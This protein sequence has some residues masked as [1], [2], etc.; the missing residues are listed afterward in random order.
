[1]SGIQSINSFL[2]IHWKNLTQN[3]RDECI[4]K[5]KAHN[6]NAKNALAI[7]IDFD[8]YSLKALNL[9]ISENL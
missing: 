8:D 6:I 1:M 7:M 2:H 4:S 3:E 9:S 5:Q